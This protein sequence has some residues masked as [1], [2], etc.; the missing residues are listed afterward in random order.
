MKKHNIQLGYKDL[1]AIKHSLKRT[2]KAK[3]FTLLNYNESGLHIKEIE[4]YKA[5][6][7]HE[8]KLL[9]RITEKINYIKDLYKI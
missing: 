6:I 1:L 4:Q 9:E 2:I 8:T 3:N 7:E 5:D